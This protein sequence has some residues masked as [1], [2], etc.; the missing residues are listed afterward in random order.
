V[1]VDGAALGRARVPTKG[2][3][4]RDADGSSAEDDART[5]PVPDTPGRGQTAERA[6]AYGD[7]DRYGRGTGGSR[8]RTPLIAA[9]L[10]AGGRR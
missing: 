6:D 10:P 7:A 3:S 8:G 4:R 2:P 5:T 9:G 1:P